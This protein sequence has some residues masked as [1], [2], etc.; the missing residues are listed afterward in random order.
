MGNVEE[1][2]IQSPANDR[3]KRLVRLRD[4][5]AR[6]R[7]QVFVAEGEA[8]NRALQAGLAPREIYGPVDTTLAEARAIYRASGPALQKASYRSDPRAVIGVFEQENV[9]LDQ[10]ELGT[11]PFV[12]IADELEKPGN[13]GAILRTAAALGVDLV[14]VPRAFD[15]Y[16][17]NVLRSSLG[18]LFLVPIA[19]ADL[20]DALPWL[21]AR[22]VS[23]VVAH[24]EG[25]SHPWEVNLTNGVALIIGGE[26]SGLSEQ[27]RSGADH[28]ISVPM[29]RGV[30]S[31]NASVTAAVLVYEVLRQRHH[32]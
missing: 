2:L 7:E 9:T 5:R 19:K 18:A 27:A 14:I 30:D 22:D 3:I 25:G 13:V 8:L 15:L 1:V 28:V 24:P 20:T 10:I 23:T 31:L 16:N 12:I 29:T 6:D 4:R 26:H 21:E 11:K 17:P 32:Q